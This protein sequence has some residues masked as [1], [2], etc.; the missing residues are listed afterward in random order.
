MTHT[1][2]IFAV[3]TAW[4]LATSDAFLF[5]C[6][7]MRLHI[8]FMWSSCKRFDMS[9]SQLIGVLTAPLITGKNCGMLCKS[10]NGMLP[11]M[12]NWLLP[13]VISRFTCKRCRSVSISSLAFLL[14][15]RTTTM[16]CAKLFAFGKTVRLDTPALRLYRLEPAVILLRILGE[17]VMELHG[18]LVWLFFKSNR[19][20]WFVIIQT[21]HRLAYPY[22]IHMAG[23][24]PS[25]HLSV[26][27]LVLNLSTIH[28]SAKINVA[29]SQ[30]PYCL[31]SSVWHSSHFV[32]SADHVL[33][34]IA[35]SPF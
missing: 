8:F 15:S 26:V 13:Q 3:S 1:S 16:S 24:N 7:S 27:K 34:V 29:H 33:S 18:Q 5:K 32:A 19:E 20:K 17:S 14:A 6:S 22:M 4:W 30:P 35:Q 11:L 10:F 12:K 31:A 23:R 28:H 21:H 2:L 9:A 25:K